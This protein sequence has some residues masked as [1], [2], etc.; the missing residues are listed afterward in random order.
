MQLA[1]IRQ[2]QW[3]VLSLIAGALI[4]YVRQEAA[5]DLAGQYGECINGQQHFEQAVI[6]V[7]QGRPRFTDISIHAR[8]VPDGRGGSKRVHVVSGLYFNGQ[9]TQEGGRLIARWQPAFFLADIPYKPMTNFAAMGKPQLAQKFQ[10]IARPTVVDF[11]DLLSESANVRYTYAWWQGMGIWQWTLAS[12][13]VVG[14]IWPIAINL[15]VYGSWR[16]PREE[17][18]IDLSKVDAHASVPQKPKATEEDRQHLQAL[19]AELESHLEPA[20]IPEPTTTSSPAPIRQ[21]Q[22]APLEPAAATAPSDREFGT[23]PDDYY[24]TERKHRK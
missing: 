8:A 24:P 14:V 21:L 18:G 23:K 6:T 9:Y 20:A 17:R 13:L 19:E 12:F 4:G 22:A 3:M 15:L 7:E 1:N 10:T 11:L 16:R 5:T 2:W